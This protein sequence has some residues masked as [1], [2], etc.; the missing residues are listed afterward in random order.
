MIFAATLAGKITLDV[1]SSHTVESVKLNILLK[2]DFPNPD[3]P[4][5]LAEKQ[6]LFFALKELEDDRTLSHYSVQEDTL[7]VLRNRLDGE[8]TRSAVQVGAD[9]ASLSASTYNDLFAQDD[10][11]DAHGDGPDD[12]PS[13]SPLD[14]AELAVLLLD[15]AQWPALSEVFVCAACGEVRPVNAFGATQKKKGSGRRCKT[16]T[17]AAFRGFKA[18]APPLDDDDDEVLS[19]EQRASVLNPTD[20]TLEQLVALGW[21]LRPP[22]GDGE[23]GQK[24][25]NDRLLLEK[26]NRTLTVAL[27]DSDADRR[28]LRF[29]LNETSAS[30]QALLGA[31]D[32]KNHL[33]Q[34]E[35]ERDARADIPA[36]L[37]AVN[38]GA[39][40]ESDLCALQTALANVSVRIATERAARRLIVE[41]TECVVCQD[42]A[43]SH[44]FVP[45]G[46]RCAC[47]ECASTIMALVP[48]ARQC[49]ICRA[50]ATYAIQ[51]YT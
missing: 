1:E 9:D 45:C 26:A 20:R 21:T 6:R 24:G 16:C 19:A 7:L 50:E 36:L 27:A 51:V 39:L 33:R 30:Q 17:A 47:Q 3:K 32:A 10:D 41:L 34:V 28:T 15:S 8:T 23:D 18:S 40:E 11:G 22:G 42:A 29:A 4:R 46:H 12:L 14:K 13:A 37:A 31:V 35:A 49:P 44:S 43:R 48:A 2:M 38:A 25:E 5:Q